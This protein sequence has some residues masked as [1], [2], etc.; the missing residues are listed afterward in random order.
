MAPGPDFWKK[1]TGPIFAMKL[2]LKRIGW[3]MPAFT[4]AVDRFCAEL[5]LTLVLPTLLKQHLRQTVQHVH[6]CRSAT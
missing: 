2:S 6:E 4:T 1:V 3:S 5:L